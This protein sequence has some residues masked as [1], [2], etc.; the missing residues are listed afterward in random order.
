[1]PFL[2]TQNWAKLG[3][4][5]KGLTFSEFLYKKEHQIWRG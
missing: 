4:P 5:A 1:M 3:S 2:D